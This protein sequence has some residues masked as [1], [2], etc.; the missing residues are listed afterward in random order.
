MAKGIGKWIC[1]RCGKVNFDKRCSNCGQKHNH[2]GKKG[3]GPC[4]SFGGV[5]RSN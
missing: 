5:Q 3:K 4:R 2:N 1:S